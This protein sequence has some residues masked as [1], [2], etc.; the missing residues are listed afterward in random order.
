LEIRIN[1]KTIKMKKIFLIIVGLAFSIA[2]C[3]KDADYDWGSYQTVVQDLSGPENGYASG[4]GYLTYKVSA[5]GGATYEWSVSGID[6][7]ITP[8]NDKTRGVGAD[9]TFNQSDVDVTATV[10]VVETTAQGVASEPATLSVNLKKFK[11]RTIDEFVGTWN[12]VYPWDETDIREVEVVKES[13]TQITINPVDVGGTDYS[14]FFTTD[15]EGW[16]EPIEVGHGTDGKITVDLNFQTGEATF[17]YHKNHLT[18][19][20]TYWYEAKTGVWDGFDMSMTLDV[21]WLYAEG[22]ADAHT[23]DMLGGTVPQYMVK[24]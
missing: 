16:G 18:N 20:G 10:S 8:F 5:R 3:Q 23:D 19:W 7:T 24:K 21:A 14:P 6:A 15:Y 13:D 4:L 9:I 22:D 17:K 11:P 2:S 1:L 12:V